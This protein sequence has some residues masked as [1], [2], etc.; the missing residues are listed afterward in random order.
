MLPSPRGMEGN[1][2]VNQADEQQAAHR[3]FS[4]AILSK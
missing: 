2:A 3:I 1:K 4:T